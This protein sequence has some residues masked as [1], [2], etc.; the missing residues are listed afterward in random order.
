MRNDKP[1]VGTDVLVVGSGPGGAGVALFLAT[2]GTPTL[3]VTKYGQLSDTPRAHITNQRTMETLRDMGLEQRLMREA[4]PWEYMGNTTFCTSLVGDELGR[5]PSWGTDTRRH[6]D[7]ELQ[8]PCTMLD[9]PQT[10]TEPVMMQAAQARGAK[11]RFD[12]EYL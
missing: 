11:V 9:A 2:Y 7:Y 12:T 4:T 1:A 3:V 10:I 6:A 5:I 8:S